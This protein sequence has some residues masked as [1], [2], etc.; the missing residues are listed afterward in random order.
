MWP[1]AV[2]GYRGERGLENRAVRGIPEVRVVRVRLRGKGNV[3]LEVRSRARLK[4][5]I[6]GWLLSN[7]ILMSGQ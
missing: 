5:M 7:W 3:E 2:R 6:A 4:V 1:G